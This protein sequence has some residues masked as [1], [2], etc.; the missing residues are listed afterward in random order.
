[1]IKTIIF[2]LLICQVIQLDIQIENSEIATDKARTL[3]VIKVFKE[4]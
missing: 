4:M 2:L 3:S 1:M